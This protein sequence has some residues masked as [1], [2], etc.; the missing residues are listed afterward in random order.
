MLL[1]RESRHQDDAHSHRL[2]IEANLH[3][4]WMEIRLR[5][6]VFDQF[7]EISCNMVSSVTGGFPH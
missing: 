3:L 7:I 6:V 1:M 4:M 2:T 5:K